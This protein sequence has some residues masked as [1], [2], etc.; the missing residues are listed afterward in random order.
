VPVAE[1][2]K[3]ICVSGLLGGLTIGVWSAVSYG[4]GGR[5]WW[6]P[7]NLVA[8]TV[9]RGAPLDGRL[10]TGALVVAVLV[11]AVGGVVVI[12]PYAVLAHGAGLSGPLLVLLAGAYANVVWVVGDYL[13]WPKLDAVAAHAFSPGV[14]WVAHL[15]GG[16]V[17]G[18]CLVGV[19]RLRHAAGDAA[20]LV[21]GS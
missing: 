14:A 11:F 3:R 4:L 10:D 7:L 17:A 15:V 19:H 6:R 13:L 16:L 12:A 18:L 5:G 1:M 8:H 9:W 2:V 20:Q 21:A